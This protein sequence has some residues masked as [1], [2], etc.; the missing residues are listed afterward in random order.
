MYQDD[1]FSEI[2]NYRNWKVFIL[3]DNR[4]YDNQDLHFFE[5]NILLYYDI[6]TII[7]RIFWND[8]FLPIVITSE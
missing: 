3:W 4:N 5:A 1:R 2:E 8:F 7:N 6:E